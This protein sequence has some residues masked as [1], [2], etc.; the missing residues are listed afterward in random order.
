MEQPA[1][2]PCCPAGD[3][4]VSILLAH[5]LVDSAQLGCLVLVQ[6]GEGPSQEQREATH[7]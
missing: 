7:L 2:H 5:E 4:S 3:V 6:K 1:L